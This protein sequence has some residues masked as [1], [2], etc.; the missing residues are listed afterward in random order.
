MVFILEERGG[1]RVNK[2][3]LKIVWPIFALLLC[4]IAIFVE[5]I[6]V[7]YDDVATATK[8]LNI[9]EEEAFSESVE[10][11]AECLVITDSTN[12]LSNM[13][14]EDMT[15]VLDDMCV[16]YEV[17]DVS[18]KAIPNLDAYRNVVLTISDLGVIK[19]DLLRITNWVEKGGSL[20]NTH[21]FELNY[22]FKVIEGKLGIVEDTKEYASID[23]IR[24]LNN[25]MIGG[26]KSFDYEDDLEVS[27]SIYL[28]KYCE[29][30]IESR[31]NHIPIL[32]ERDY[33]K[34]K[35]VI[36]NQEIHGKVDRGWICAA[37]TLLQD[38]GIYPV[39]NASTFYIDDFP[40]PGPIGENEYVTRDYKMNIT[41]FWMNIWWPEL[42]TW[43]K[44]YNI[45]YTGMII[46]TYSDLVK[47]PFNRQTDTQR[48]TFYG[49]ML[50]NNGGE[51]GLHGYNHIP[52]C[53]KGVDALS[54]DYKLWET[55]EEMS[56]SLTELESFSS[57]LFPGQNFSVYVP[58]SDNLSETGRN[59]L[60]ETLPNIKVI[61]SLYLPDTEADSYT[62]EF[63]VSDDGI[64][65]TPRITS[66][67][68]LDDSMKLIA[69]NELNFHYVQSHF[70]HPDDVLDEERG[71]QLGWE[72]L[73]TRFED[74]L[75]WIHTSVPNIRNVTGS[76]MGEAVKV[77]DALSMKKEWKDHELAIKLG[78]FSREAY[79]M[80]R[81]NVKELE[82]IEGASY[83][84]M[85]G[86][87]YLIHAQS[88]EIR[89]V[90]E[91]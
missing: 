90:W 11:Q 72:E 36:M 81:L 14:K 61:A 23:G 45:V 39:I 15:F 33:G 37:Y 67:Y 56:A 84:H 86:N 50:L 9:Q 51:L 79:F 13:Y 2:R 82:R 5:R 78:G 16:V 17:V 60:T 87:L 62:Q 26:N 7:K 21:T 42:I 88:D 25:F 22:Y 27:L 24:T 20:M 65:E 1:Q 85:T 6:G 18:Q 43:E 46:E 10:D 68:E 47:K 4:G 70:I 28:D 52:L 64:V 66:G 71:S 12:E 49:N 8:Y 57:S 30:Y 35:F 73:S 77:F 83:E 80:L 34:G 41:D 89:I 63:E 31:N 76:Q 19:D 91:E 53:L 44:K 58:P 59:I 74:Y 55:K 54:K 40:S 69:Y 32:W 29:I 38:V 75:S 48:F 3:L